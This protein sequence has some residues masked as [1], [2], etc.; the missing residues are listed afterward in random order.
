MKYELLNGADFAYI[1]DAC[2]ELMIRKYVLH[3]G[4]TKL[5]ELHESSV[6]YVSK[7]AQN[8]IILKLNN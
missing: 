4:I 7:S 5:V 1:G 2:Y 6:K 3:T 8:K